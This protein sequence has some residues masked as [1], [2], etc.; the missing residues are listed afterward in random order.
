MNES[1]FRMCTGGHIAVSRK[2]DIE[3]DILVFSDVKFGDVE[4]HEYFYFPLRTTVSVSVSIPGFNTVLIHLLY[5]MRR[6]SEPRC[7]V[8]LINES[9]AELDLF[10]IPYI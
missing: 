5:F 2:R 10:C 7:P 6:R 8:Q 3:R 9:A 4:G 1:L